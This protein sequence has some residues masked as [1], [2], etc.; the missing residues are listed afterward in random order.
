MAPVSLL[1]VIVVQVDKLRQLEVTE[2][3][4][5]PP[6]Q[7]PPAPLPPSPPLCNSR[8][9]PLLLVLFHLTV[10]KPLTVYLY[11]TL[12][13]CWHSTQSPSAPFI[14]SVNLIMTQV[15]TKWLEKIPEG[16]RFPPR[17]SLNPAD[18]W[19][20]RH[21][22]LGS[23]SSGNKF[24]MLQGKESLNAPGRIQTLRNKSG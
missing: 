1:R 14:L 17:N 10:N 15:T 9:G 16:D 21:V 2:T 19:T 11:I 5:T 20:R 18:A 6:T 7:I 23:R 24:K 4:N 12:F 3:Q 8:A 22:C 13:G